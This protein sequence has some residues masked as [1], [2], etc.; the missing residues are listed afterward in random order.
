[1]SSK[2]FFSSTIFVTIILLVLL[3][4]PTIIVDPFFHYRAPQGNYRLNNQRY[5]NDGIARHFEYDALITGS[6][7]SEN[8]KV[9]EFNE[10]F[11]TNAVK[12]PYSGAQFQE[13]DTAV[14]IALKSNA[15]LKLV[16]R[17]LDLMMLDN[18]KDS[19]RYESY[20]T[21][22]YD[23]NLVNDVYYFLNKEVFINATMD[24][25]QLRKNGDASTTFDEYSSWETERTVKDQIDEGTFVREAL[26]EEQRIFTE[27]DKKRVLGNIEQNVIQTA[28]ENPDVIFV[29]FMPP[30]SCMY[31][32]SLIRTGQWDYHIA[33]QK[34]VI[35]E[36]LKYDNIKLFSFCNYYDV[37]CN[38]ELYRDTL[39]YNADI[40]SWI[41]QCIESEEGLLT[42]DNYLKYLED[43]YGFYG[44]LDC[45]DYFEK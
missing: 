3:A 16:F 40:S 33:V 9:S 41:L 18:D 14:N 15:E 38:L 24:T 2:K 26:S 32:D 8:F 43:I 23:D 6:S 4:L 22:L 31:F 1:M 36:I 45:D 35:E 42:E 20:P 28:K 10:L 34:C 5:Q 21:Y 30:Y 27:A 39:H 44:A 13:I 29:L 7:M 11:E 19:V 17:S 37:V 25:I 12:I